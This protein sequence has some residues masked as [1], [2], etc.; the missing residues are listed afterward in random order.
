[1]PQ[2]AMRVVTRHVRLNGVLMA[3]G[4]L[5]DTVLMSTIISGMSLALLLEMTP[6]PKYERRWSGIPGEQQAV[7]DFVGTPLGVAS[8]DLSGGI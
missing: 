4:L 5:C 1:M 3:F 2:N 8:G 6:P 7:V